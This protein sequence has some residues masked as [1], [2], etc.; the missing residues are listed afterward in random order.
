[1]WRLEQSPSLGIALLVVICGQ[2][3]GGHQPFLLLFGTCL[4]LHVHA[5]DADL[6]AGRL[7]DGHKLFTGWCIGLLQ[8]VNS[9]VA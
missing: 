6:L 5:L 2:D 4:H 8:I 3:S 9:C 7:L 1:M